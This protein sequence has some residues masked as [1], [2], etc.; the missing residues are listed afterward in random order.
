ML[1]QPREGKKKV[2]EHIQN[3]KTFVEKENK[4]F[5][6]YHLE[7]ICYS[8]KLSPEFLSK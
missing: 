7:Q 5:K 4:R 2:K 1:M 8:S 3:L 6:I